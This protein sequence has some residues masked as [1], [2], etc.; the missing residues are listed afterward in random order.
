MFY[1]SHM[2]ITYRQ[3][4]FSHKMNSLKKALACL[5]ALAI[6]FM[7]F[8]CRNTSDG[9]SDSENDCNLDLESYIFL[10]HRFA[11]ENASINSGDSESTKLEWSNKHFRDAKDYMIEKVTD[12]KHKVR[13]LEPAGNFLQP[14]CDEIWGTGNVHGYE[15]GGSGIDL[16][17]GNCENRYSKLLGATSAKLVLAGDVNPDKYDKFETHYAALAARSY[18]DSLG[19]LHDSER[20]PLIRE[21]ADINVA[22]QSE[23]VNA[24][25]PANDYYN[26]ENTLKDMLE[27]VSL[28]TGV[29]VGTLI[30]AVNLNLLNVGMYGACDLGATASFQ[31]SGNTSV[32]Q[33]PQLT[34]LTR[35][36]LLHNM[37]TWGQR[38][39]NRYVNEQQNSQDQEQ[40]N[41]L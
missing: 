21:R 41:S 40:G 6:I 9:G 24:N 32:L 26:V 38:Y 18:N 15:N 28:E 5:S 17:I 14:I 1:N 2:A 10:R 25:Y 19:S 16:I 8:S 13:D 30:D 23:P 34:N 4:C 22:L 29:S 20:F 33:R 27:T 35:R 36:D 7:S 11:E 31:L 39:I 12:F 3:S 37:G